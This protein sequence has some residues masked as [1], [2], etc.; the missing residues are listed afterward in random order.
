MLARSSLPFRVACRRPLLP[1]CALTLALVAGCSAGDAARDETPSFTGSPSTTYTPS[2][3]TPSTPNTPANPQTPSNPQTP[4]SPQTPSN[5]DTG[6]DLPLAP[7]ANTDQGESQLGSASMG[8]TGTSSERY[9]K[10]DVTRDGQNY[11]FMAN[12]WGPGF[13]KHT[14]S[15]S[16]TSFTVQS[17]EGDQG[18]NYEPAAYPTV[19]CGAYSDARSRECGLPAALD[20]LSSLRTG[21]SWNANGNDGE[22]NAAYD[23]WLGTSDE[24]SSFSGY[25]MVWYR[26]PAG[27]QP[28]GSLMTSNITVANVPGSWNIWTGQVGGRPIINYVR[29]E[30]QD[31]PSMEF[32]ILDFVDDVKTRGMTLAGTHVLSVA[33]GFEIWKGPIQ[34]L[35]SLDFY[36]DPQ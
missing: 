24:R 22:Y 18:P 13:D 28:A 16:G 29:A 27:Q 8:G 35:Q 10:T 21:W 34:N 30:H 7:G 3:T 25:L 17:L 32:D 33:V 9:F 26:E 2:G 36:V 19:F 4:G 6:G 15:Y 14:V 1:S 20:S 31:T 12:G 23:I 11:F 5:E